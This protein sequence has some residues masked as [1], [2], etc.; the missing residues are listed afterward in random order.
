MEKVVVITGGNSGIGLAMAHQLAAR[1]ARVCLACRNQAKA[2]EARDLILAKT[3]SARIE[4]YSLDLASFASIRQFASELAGRH[5][6]IDV[7]I[8]NAGAAPLT[9][10]FTQEGFEMQFGGNYLG[11]FLL[12]HLLLPLLQAGVQHKGEAR[13]VNVAS[14]MHMFGRIRPDTFRGMKRYSP[15]SA[16]AQSKLANLMFS[17][18]LARRLPTGVTSQAMH[19]G[20]VDSEIWR[21]LPRPVYLM[22]KPFLITP[23]RA[24]RLG[25]DL[26]LSAEHAGVNGGYYTAQWPRPLSR[27][28]RSHEAQ[29]ELYAASCE[30]A[31]IP[32]LPVVRQG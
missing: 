7:L 21:D 8:N 25:A 1:G 16:Y 22:L 18:A 17:N 9:Q 10:Q 23:E 3:P 26:A 24:G 19:P 28:A 31:G 5:D 27:T 6:H 30:L 15:G 4:L 13:I 20:G 2:A 11:P 32:G 14:I 12:T 29:D